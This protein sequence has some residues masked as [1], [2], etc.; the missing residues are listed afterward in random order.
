MKTLRSF[1]MTV[2][3]VMIL[4]LPAPAVEGIQTLAIL[5]FDNNS[6]TE[7]EKYA[8]LSDGL[9]AMLITD[10]NKN[11]S[12]L[13]VIERNKIKSILKEIALGQMG[14]V[15][16]STAI[17]AGKILGA[18]SIAFGSFTIMG[19][20]IRIDVRIIKVESSELVMAE[21][22]SGE[23][24]NFMALETDLATK[25]ADALKTSLKGSSGKS[26]SSIDAALYFSKGIDAMDKGN[27][28]E[29][30]TLF[31]KAIEIDPTYKIQVQAIK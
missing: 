19:D 1:M 7:P 2:L 10:L 9:A 20:M 15:D 21:S 27:K 13:T 17:E 30:Q 6:I 29:A 23:M 28:K 8:P 14:G 18:Q 25:I 12:V 5:P 11:D 22:V 24:K 16:Q 4:P 3:V 31:N 26:K